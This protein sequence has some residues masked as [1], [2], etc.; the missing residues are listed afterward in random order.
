MRNEHYAYDF[1]SKEKNA[2]ATHLFYEQ[3]I[4]RLK[5]EVSNLKKVNED[6]EWQLENV[7]QKLLTKKLDFPYIH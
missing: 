6:L 3:I 2:E 5:E 7:E 1:G 4:Q